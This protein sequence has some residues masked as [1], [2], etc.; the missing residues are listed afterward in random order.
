MDCLGRG[1][2][3]GCYS[4]SSALPVPMAAPSVDHTPSAGPHPGCLPCPLLYMLLLHLLTSGSL[5]F[6]ASTV[7]LHT[8]QSIRDLTPR[9]TS[10]GWICS[11]LDES[12]SSRAH[13]CITPV[14]SMNPWLNEAMD[15]WAG[16]L[17]RNLLRSPRQSWGS[18]L[19]FPTPLPEL[20]PSQP[21]LLII[22]TA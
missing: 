6:L 1:H 2:G 5:L 16:C 3:G 4:T 8:A 17:P 21:R 14:L 12:L 11:H 20:P 18:S 22:V 9:N 7:S 19:G 13:V 10:P 15:Q